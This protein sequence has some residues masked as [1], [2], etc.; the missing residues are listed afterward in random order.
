MLAR[1]Q[2]GVSL[3]WKWIMEYFKSS[4]TLSSLKNNKKRK[5]VTKEI[6]GIVEK[7]TIPF[8][9]K[10]KKILI[11]YG[12]IFSIVTK[13]FLDIILIEWKNKITQNKIILWILLH[14][15]VDFEKRKMQIF[16]HALKFL[17]YPYIGC[18]SVKKF[19]LSIFILMIITYHN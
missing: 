12:T 11:L 14:F 18:I 19:S 10:Q 2:N 9:T 6:A 15:T 5:S 8:Y 17:K 13:K 3:R 16:V 4:F 7:V 1:L